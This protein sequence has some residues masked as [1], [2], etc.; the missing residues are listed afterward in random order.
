VTQDEVVLRGDAE[1]VGDA[2]EE[3]EHGGDVNGFGDLIFGPARLA[4]LLDVLGGRAI[5]RLG[6]Q[7]DIVQQAALCRTQS[8]VIN[9]SFQDRCDTLFRGSLNTQEVDVAVQS[10]RTAIEI[11]DIAGDHL[12][13][14]AREVALGEMD[15]VGELHHLAQEIRAGAE[16]L[17]DTR[18]LFPA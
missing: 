18:N 13:V 9:F 7:F 8:C 10:I 3:R 2:V 4:Q 11:G 15:S 14:S 17:D 1:G 5:G 6:D 12:L 16:T